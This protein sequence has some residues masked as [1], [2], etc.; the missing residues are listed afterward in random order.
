MAVESGEYNKV[1]HVGKGETVSPL[2]ALSSGLANIRTSNGLISKIPTLLPPFGVFPWFS[3][4]LGSDPVVLLCHVRHHQ[5]HSKLHLVLAA[6]PCG[7]GSEYPALWCSK[8]P[9]WA[10]PEV[11]VD[12]EVVGGIWAFATAS[13]T[14]NGFDG[15]YEFVG[16]ANGNWQE[17]CGR[18]DCSDEESDIDL[19]FE[20]HFE[21]RRSIGFKFEQV[22]LRD[23]AKVAKWEFLKTSSRRERDA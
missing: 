1:R 20:S 7:I 23:C 9:L 6:L 13:G 15:V 14:Q 11:L 3:H 12:H 21:S 22:E 10:V 19:G 8:V 2:P 18:V 17:V 4:S 5:R 16:I